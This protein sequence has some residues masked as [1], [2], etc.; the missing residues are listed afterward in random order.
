MSGMLTSPEAA[1]SVNKFLDERI[2]S[3]ARAI[4]GRDAEIQAALAV[5]SILGLTLAKHF[6]ELDAF[7]HFPDEEI[8]T[9][10][11]SWVTD[12][13]PV[14]ARQPPIVEASR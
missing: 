1:A 5:S 14:Q 7:T 10:A 13:L 9:A 12:G 2:A 6:L 4:G 11:R 3:L 8:A